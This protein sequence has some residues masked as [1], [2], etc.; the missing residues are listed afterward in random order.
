M[1]PC[2]PALAGLAPPDCPLCRAAVTQRRLATTYY[3]EIHIQTGLWVVYISAVGCVVCS[4]QVTFTV[5]LLCLCA[6][7]GLPVQVLPAIVSA[8]AP[9]SCSGFPVMCPASYDR[10]L[11]P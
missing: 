9:V 5:C 2:A 8:G 6:L 4:V 7:V 11:A 3:S 10:P 1:S